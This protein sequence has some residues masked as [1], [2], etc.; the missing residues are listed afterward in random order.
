MM[1]GVA[2]FSG[3]AAALARHDTDSVAGTTKGSYGRKR[4]PR[5][6]VSHDDTR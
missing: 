6:A 3:E 1:D 4:R 2:R 5:V